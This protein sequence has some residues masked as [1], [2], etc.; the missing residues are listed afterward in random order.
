[1]AFT[2]CSTRFSGTAVGA[3]RTSKPPFFL[4]RD[5]AL[6]GHTNKA[7]TIVHGNGLPARRALIRVPGRTVVG[8][9]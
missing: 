4:S 8:S 3:V 7:L 2:N 5:G 1:M 9:P 6:V